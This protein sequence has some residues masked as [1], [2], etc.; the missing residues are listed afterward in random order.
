MVHQYDGMCPGCALELE[1][2]AQIL[3]PPIWAYDSPEARNLGLMRGAAAVALAL[4]CRVLALG[5]G[6][7]RGG[8]SAAS[9]GPVQTCGCWAGRCG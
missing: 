2:G 7:P 6:R 8:D 3:L 1:W 9:S 5:L 4:G